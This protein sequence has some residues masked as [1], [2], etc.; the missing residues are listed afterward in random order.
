MERTEKPQLTQ[1]QLETHLWDA[2]ALLRGSI[3]SGDYKIYIFGL[4]FYKRLCDV[5]NEKYETLLQKFNGDTQKA[6][7][8]KEHRFHIPLGSMWYEDLRLESIEKETNKEVKKSDKN[9]EHFTIRDSHFDIGSRLQKA[10][11]EIEKHNPKLKGVFQYVDFSNKDR[12]TDELLDRLLSHFETVRM[13]TCDVDSHILGNSYEYL[14]AKFADDAGKKGGEFYTPKEVVRLLVE[15]L[16][17]EEGNSLYDP[18]CGSGGML[19]EAV[20]FLRRSNKDGQKVSLYGQE[21]NINTFAICKMALFLQDIDKAY[22]ERGD[23]LLDPKH[24]I[25]KSKQENTLKKFDVILANPPFSLRNWGFTVWNSKEGD[26]FGRTEWGI[27][28]KG[29]GDYAF[30]QHMLCS[31]KPKGKIG[32]VVPMG[33]LFRGGKEKP[34]RQNLIDQDLIYAVVGLGSNLFYGASIPAALI[35]LKKGKEAKMKNKVLIVN[36]TKHIKEGIAQSFLT[37]NHIEKI[38]G[39]VNTYSEEDLFSRIV[40]KEEII[41]NGYNLNIIRYVRTEPPPAKIDIQKSLQK[42][43]HIKSELDQEYQTFQS[44]F[45]EIVHD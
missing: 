5:W 6:S 45:E 3:D 41:E 7:D 42:L 26:P 2:A 24:V 43:Q 40:D 1:E 21:K 22:I 10:F 13:R 31:L 39:V 17:P 28:P 29:Y 37:Q 35:F 32:V 18:T 16:Q 4:L 34:I 25:K 36:A 9:I 8:P 15:I 23:T 20:N 19:L 12:F 38:A 33:V 14:I 27:P 11:G 30:I 44:L